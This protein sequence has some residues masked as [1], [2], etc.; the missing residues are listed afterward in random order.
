MDDIILLTLDEIDLRDEIAHICRGAPSLSVEIHEESIV[1]TDSELN[2]R[3]YLREDDVDDVPFDPEEASFLQQALGAG[4][5][6]CYVISYWNLTGV[7]RL[8]CAL[9]RDRKVV[10]DDDRG[11]LFTGEEFAMAAEDWVAGRY[12]GPP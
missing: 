8:V 10:V 11:N 2:S 1:V 4:A 7:A 9:I 5:K 3:Y 12:F 6:F